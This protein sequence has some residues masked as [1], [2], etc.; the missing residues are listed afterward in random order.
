MDKNTSLTAQQSKLLQA[1]HYVTLRDDLHSYVRAAWPIVEPAT[2]FVDNWHIGLICE[3]L[4]AVTDFQL[5]NLI[6]NIPPRHMKSLL[7]SVFWPTWSWIK[8]PALHWLTGSYAEPLAIR[9]TLK[10]RRILQHPW[11]RAAFGHIFT[12]TTD[13]NSKHRYENNRTGTRLAFGFNAAV[14][15]EGADILI[16]DDPLKAQDAANPTIRNRVNETYDT[17]LTTRANDTRLARRVIIMQRLH[18]EDLTGHLLEKLDPSGAM[19]YEHLCLPTE[20]EPRRYISSLGLSDPRTTPGQLLWPARFGPAENLAAH[21][22]LGPRAYA[23]QHAQRPTPETG[24]IYQVDW[25]NNRNR[26]DPPTEDVVARW[27]SW[28]TAFKDQAHNDTSAFVVCDLLADHRL[29]I[30]HAASYRLQFPQLASLI[31][32]ETHHWNQSGLLYGVIIEDK[33]SGISLFQTLTQSAPPAVASLLRAFSPG[34][35]SKATRAR[36]ASLWCER[37]CVILP[38]PSQQVPWLHDFE[39]QLYSFPSARINDPVDALTQAILYLEH[40]LARGW[41]ARSTPRPRPTR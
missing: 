20:Y 37:G 34:Q 38:Q 13:Q 5:N 33:A 6:I 17:A 8:T 22:D 27:L 25:W 1:T 19:R 36:Q 14:T 16:V 41:H 31:I 10:S 39:E 32:D 23:G 9:D 40:L 11:Y 24:S 35:Q 7:V 15:G 3:Y 4:Q 12:L 29:F 30:R 18:P 28:D 26:D 2:P 21:S